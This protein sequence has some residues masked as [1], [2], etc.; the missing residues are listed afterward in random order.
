MSDSVTHA[1][2]DAKMETAAARM[3]LRLAQ[4][5]KDMRGVVGEMRQEMNDFRLEIQP[6]KN[7]KASIWGSTA[8]IVGTIFAA[9]ALS[10]S[11]FDSGRDTSAAVQDVRHLLEQVK[12]QQ[13]AQPVPQA[14]PAPQQ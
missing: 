12:A 6:L 1:E 9:V 11:A 5:D 2:L 13:A 8:V 10:F 4:F 7:M 14:A 3:D